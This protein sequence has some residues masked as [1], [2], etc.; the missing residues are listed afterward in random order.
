MHMK[1]TP[2]ITVLITIVFDGRSWEM[3]T[4]VHIIFVFEKHILLALVD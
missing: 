3:G 2:I 4:W 1:A